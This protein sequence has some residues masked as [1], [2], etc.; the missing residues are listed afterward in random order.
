MTRIPFV[1]LLVTMLASS[2]I[3]V[4]NPHVAMAP[5]IWRGVLLVEEI[6]PVSPPAD[7]RGLRFDEVTAGQ[8]PFLFEVIYTTPDSFHIELINGEERI[9]AEHIQVGWD[10]ATARDTIRIDFPVYDTYIEGV[11]QEGALDG[12]W[13]VNYKDDYAIPFKAYFGKGFRFTQLRKEPAADLS[14]RWAAIFDSGSADSFPAIGEFI[15]EGN[16]LLGTFLTE[17]GDYRYLEG[18]VQADKFY[19]SCFDGSHAF[20]F[21]GRIREDGSLMGMFQSGKHY[22][23]FWEARRDEQTQLSDPHQLTQVLPGS[24]RL[25]FTFPNPN[26]QRISL[27]DP[28]YEGKVKLVQIM[29]TWCPNCYDETRFLTEYLQNNP[30]PN[31]AVIGLAFERYRDEERAYKAIQTYKE[32]MQVPYE[33][34]HAGYYNKQ[35]AREALPMLNEIFSYPTL[36]FLD[37][38]NQIRR[39]HTGFSGP[40][41][42]SYSEFSQEFDT[43]VKTLLQ[44]PQ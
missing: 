39:I 24:E 10:R 8:L 1:A 28:V 4:D 35:E 20:L 9:R 26:G 34:L 33:I 19:L 31:L 2:C 43:F 42:S 3:V 15:Q 32:L 7:G 29:G 21:E 11:F 17:T 14:G 44:S 38:N 36:I 18:T 37:R 22:K 23:V 30:H 40:A 41:T 16:R 13:V 6:S 12:K 25:Q 27:N 5:G